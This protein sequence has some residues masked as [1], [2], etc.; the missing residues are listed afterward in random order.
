M[1]AFSGLYYFSILLSFW[2]KNLSN[3]L[4]WFITLKLSIFCSSISSGLFKGVKKFFWPMSEMSSESDT[5]SSLYFIDIFGKSNDFSDLSSPFYKKSLICLNF[6][7]SI[8]SC[9]WFYK[10]CLELHL[11]SILSILMYLASVC[12][13]LSRLSKDTF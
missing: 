8:S 3:L 7:L 2:S 12:L 5:S 10:A 1:G 4:I 6:F 9:Y 13:K 11:F